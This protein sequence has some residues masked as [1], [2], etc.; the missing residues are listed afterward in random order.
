MKEK[1]LEEK[2]IDPEF[3]RTRVLTSREREVLKLLAEGKTMQEAGNA[4][5]IKPRTIAFHKYKIMEKFCLKS[6]SEFIKL[7]LRRRI[8]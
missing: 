1:Q 8:G 7:A 3:N 2:R 6:N 5:H 4:L